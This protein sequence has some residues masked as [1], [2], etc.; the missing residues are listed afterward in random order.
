VN[1]LERRLALRELARRKG[2]ADAGSDVRGLILSSLFDKQR[3]FVEDPAQY[4]DALCPRR[5]GKTTLV[6]AHHFTKLLAAPPNR[7][8]RYWAITADRAYQLMWR[9]MIRCAEKFSIRIKAEETTQTIHVLDKGSEIRLVGAD[10]AKEGEKKRGE[11]TVLETVDE[12]SLY[13]SFLKSLLEDVIGPSLLDHRGECCLLGTPGVLFDGYWFD[14]SGPDADKSDEGRRISKGWSHHRWDVYDNP[15]MPNAR[16]DIEKLRL[17]R[18]WSFDHPTYLREYRGQWILDAE[19]LFYRFNP[20]LNTYDGT[21]PKLPAGKAWDYV[22][23]WDI[24]ANDAMALVLWAECPEFSEDLYEAHSWK[25]SGAS[26]SE[27]ANEVRRL[28]SVHGHVPRKVGDTG[29]GGK[30]T[31]N[32]MALREHL[33]FEAAKKT[34]KPGIVRFM[35][36]AF[37]SGRIKVRRGSALADEY[38]TLLKNPDNPE[39]EDPACEN[40]CTDAALYSFRRA[41]HFQHEKQ[42]ETPQVGTIQY[43]DNIAKDLERAELLRLEQ[44]HSEEWW[45]Q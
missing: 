39:E 11:A 22:L 45:E 19:G 34:D 13:G 4:K 3:S 38:A 12:A 35:N 6:P 29:G 33:Y 43:F 18:G 32:E 24:G 14:V 31:V 20:D 28:E 17:A 25:K 8:S 23:G 2:L 21:L 7:L 5:A 9:P 10:K 15:F 16:E 44:K 27:V 41:R 30:V 1:H 40:H 37:T 42:P 36:D 26:I